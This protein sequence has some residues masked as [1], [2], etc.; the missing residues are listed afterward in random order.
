MTELLKSLEA[1]G[2]DVDRAL[3]NEFAG[4]DLRL[5]LLDLQHAMGDLRSV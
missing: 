2:G 1:G 4:I 5:S 3:N